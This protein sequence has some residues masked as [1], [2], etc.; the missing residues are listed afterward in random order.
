MLSRLI[1]DVVAIIMALVTCT[2]NT[3]A[4][5]IKTGEQY[6]LDPDKVYFAS[7][8]QNMAWGFD[9]QAVFVFGDGKIYSYNNREDSMGE[10]TVTAEKDKFV[11]IAEN[12]RQG[13]PDA[14][15]DMDYLYEMYEAAIRVDPNAE[16]SSKHVRYDGGQNA[17]YFY[18]EDG[19]RVTCAS[20]G[21]VNY[22]IDD[23]YAKQ[24]EKLWKYRMLHCADI[25]K[26]E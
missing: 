20:N 25:N 3:N 16:K 4:G 22:D 1:M 24:V 8:Y 11:G 10:I 26:I 5:N 23:S 12:M 6:E 2:G 18:T 14:V 15:M 9:E 17:L 21:D 7:V 13:E 19:T